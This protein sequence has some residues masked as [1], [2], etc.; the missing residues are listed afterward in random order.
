M[1]PTRRFG[2][3][4]EITSCATEATACLIAIRTLQK[5]MEMIRDTTTPAI[6]DATIQNWINTLVAIDRDLAENAISEATAQGAPGKIA[7][8][9]E[10]LASGDADAANGNFDTA[11]EDYRK[12]WNAVTECSSNSKPGKN[13][14]RAN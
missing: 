3:Q 7:K 9:L 8:A 11:I 5:L 2:Y 12:A 4:M 6:P 1:R 13:V 14:V 10:Y